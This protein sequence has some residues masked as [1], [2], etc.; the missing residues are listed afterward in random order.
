MSI[1][2]R[3]K[4]LNMRNILHMQAELE[5]LDD[6][7]DKIVAGDVKSGTNERLSVYRMKNAQF[8]NDLKRKGTLEMRTLLEKYSQY[9]PHTALLQQAELDRF[10][11]ANKR[12][13]DN[14]VKYIKRRDCLNDFLDGR[15]MNP[16]EEKNRSDLIS[17]SSRHAE[18]DLLT[19]WISDSIP[20]LHKRFLSR[21]RTPAAGEAC[22]FDYD[23]NKLV[24]ITSV[25]STVVSCLLPVLS[26]VCLYCLQSTVAKLGVTIA[27]TSLFSLALVVI[28]NCR[29][30]EVFAATA[31]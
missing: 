24:A 16:W 15:E 9:N 5:I 18:G 19:E 27:F 23:D 30:V 11:P 6:Q 3:Y 4:A 20:W 12:D 31:T 2:R 28:T 8:P 10:E 25:V 29:R 14:L 1:V 7:W 17:L 21:F 22:V 13:V 26:M